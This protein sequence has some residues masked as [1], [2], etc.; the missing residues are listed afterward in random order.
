[1]QD[2]FREHPEIY[3]AELADDDEQEGSAAEAPTPEASLVKETE[4]AAA[5]TP[6]E[7]VKAVEEKKED[8]K[9]EEADNKET[10]VVEV[11]KA[12][13]DATAANKDTKQ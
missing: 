2:C 7:P 12:A 9:K 5:A 8:E 11:P 10:K 6:A 3:A 13:S 4:D 1:M